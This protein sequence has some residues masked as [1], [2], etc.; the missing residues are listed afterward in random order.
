MSGPPTLSAYRAI[1]GDA[2]VDTLQRLGDALRGTRL[3][4]VNATRTGGGVAEILA[5]LLPLMAEVGLDPRWEVIHAAGEPDFYRVTKTFHNAIQGDPVE[6]HPGD[7]DLFMRVN[8]KNAAEIS[9]DADVV[10]LHDPQ[11]IGLVERH[12]RGSA[13]RF[14][15]RCH[16]D[17]AHPDPRVWRFLERFLVRFDAGIF[18]AA[19]F[20]KPMPIPQ[21]LVAPAID[22]LSDKNRPLEPEQVRAVCER[23]GLDPNRPMLTQVSRFDRFKDPLGVIRTYQLVRETHDCQLVL[24][25]GGASDDPEGA[26]VLEEVRAA[27]DGDPNIHVLLL[28]PDANVEINA[29]QRA[30]TV[31]LQKSLREGFGLTVAEGMWKGRPVIGG[32]TGG[33]PLQIIEGVTGYLVS[34]PEG[35]AFRARYLLNHPEVAGEMGRRAMEHVRQNFLVTRNLREYL[36][37]LLALRRPGDRMISL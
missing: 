34:T 33:I 23:H 32:L 35:A 13:R 37:L 4:H 18:S 12:E 17:A 14:V 6:L 1:L 15:W 3:V 27:A 29:L 8:R 36:L 16:I 21:F 11:P 5:R 28:P 9:L 10:V 20:T 22:P 19:Q 31:I 30:A 25:G 2:E 26:A 7:F 24:A